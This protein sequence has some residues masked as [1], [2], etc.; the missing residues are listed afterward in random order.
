M[1]CNAFNRFLSNCQT[2]RSFDTQFA[3][4]VNVTS[5]VMQATMQRQDSA[6]LFIIGI[7][8]SDIGITTV[9]VICDDITKS[10]TRIVPTNQ[11][12]I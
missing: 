5:I 7:N 12:L 11:C 6:L 10:P 2:N 8:C 4:D 9:I 3:T 1:I